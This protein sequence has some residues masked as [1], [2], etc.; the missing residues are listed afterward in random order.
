MKSCWAFSAVASVEALNQIFTGE[1]ISLSEQELG[2]CDTVGGGCNRGLMNHAFQF[3]I[4]NG[5]ID[6]KED[7]PYIG[8]DEKCNATKVCVEFLLIFDGK[9][10]KSWL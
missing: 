7:Y 6:T 4:D 10:K 1:L 5:G 8:E 9:N 3:I 2:D